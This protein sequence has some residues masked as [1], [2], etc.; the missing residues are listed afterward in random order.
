VR[1]VLQN[2]TETR[3]EAHA[4]RFILI[5][6]IDHPPCGLQLAVKNILSPSDLQ[7]AICVVQR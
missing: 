4:L 1:A 5:A 6:T 2:W 7:A 3:K